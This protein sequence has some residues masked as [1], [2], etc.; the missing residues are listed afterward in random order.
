MARFA[1]VAL[2][3]ALASGAGAARAAEGVQTP[4]FP[5]VRNDVA[6]TLWLKRNTSLPPGEAVV[7]GPD[8]VLVVVTDDAVPGAAHRV[9][10]RQ[11]ATSIDFVAR[12]GGRSV[13]GEV[14]IACPTRH[15]RPVALTLYA[16]S[17]LTGDRIYTEG[18]DQGWRPPKPGSAAALAMERVCGPASAPALTTAAAP[19]S[20]PRPA[21]PPPGPVRAAAA[22]RPAAA[23]PGGA[24]RVQIGAFNSQAAARE[25]WDRLVRAFPAETAGKALKV[26]ETVVQGRQYFRTFVDGF[27]TGAA[28][29]AA[30]AAFSARGQ[31]CFV[32]GG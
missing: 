29:K 2:V 8:N 15:V 11:E 1:V 10:L 23:G 21:A 20:P 12:T 9:A 22:S 25:A 28:A 7:F 27:A 17:D 26:E 30:C 32:R 14:E 6:V 16:G 18:P 24:A 31:A 5:A 4:D 13:G 3:A 19:P